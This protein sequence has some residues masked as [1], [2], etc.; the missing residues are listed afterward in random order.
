MPGSPRGTLQPLSWG[1]C[2]RQPCPPQRVPTCPLAWIPVSLRCRGVE[3]GFSQCGFPEPSPVAVLPGVSPASAM[4]LLRPWEGGLGTL[5][6][7]PEPGASVCSAANSVQPEQ[8]R[9]QGWTSVSCFHCRP[10]GSPPLPM[11]GGGLWSLSLR[12]GPAVLSGQC[13]R[14]W[15]S[16]NKAS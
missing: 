15:A 10:A 4:L 6:L 3:R 2:L 5:P 8:L 13:P 14:W 11:D 9:Q 1:S 7:L 16:I 12:T